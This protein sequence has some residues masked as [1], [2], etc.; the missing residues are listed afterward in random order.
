MLLLAE[1]EAVVP[2]AMFP[3]SREI[4]APLLQ[5]AH[6]FEQEGAAGLLGIM[7]G[8]AVQ[9]A[10]VAE[11]LL[12]PDLDAAILRA[13]V[14]LSRDGSSKG[15]TAGEIAARAQVADTGSTITGKMAGSILRRYG[16]GHR[17][18]HGRYLYELP[19]KLVAELEDRYGI[20][21]EQT[22]EKIDPPPPPRWPPK[23][24]K[25]PAKADVVAEGDVGELGDHLRGVPPSENHEKPTKVRPGKVVL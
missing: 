17:I 15:P 23:S 13:A 10:E 19:P 4:W 5:L 8:F 1:P 21:L 25:S 18:L 6:L 9:K 20:V 3:R 11:Q 2:S 16:I 7:Q 14:Y 24:P 12:V 22:G